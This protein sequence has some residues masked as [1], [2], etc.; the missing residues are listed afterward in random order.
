MVLRYALVLSRAVIS[1]VHS[2]G[3]KGRDLRRLSIHASPRRSEPE[4]LERRTNRQFQE[5]WDYR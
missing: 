5:L 3:A 4:W 1:C 2:S